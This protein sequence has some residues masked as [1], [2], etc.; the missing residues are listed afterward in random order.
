MLG[1]NSKG[2]EEKIFGR[3]AAFLVRCHVSPN[4]VTVAGTAVTTVIALTLFPLGRLWLGAVVLGLFATTD[5]LDGT[6]ARIKGTASDFGAFLDSTLDR[7][8]DA[9][10]LAGLTVYLARTGRV[11]GVAAGVAAIAASAIVPYAR[12]RAEALGYKAS[13]GIAE[14]SDRLIATLV[15][16]FLTGVGLPWWV[17]AGG[18]GLVAL[19]SL[20]TVGQRLAAVWRQARTGGAAE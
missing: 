19:G 4:V 14:R 1:A 6:M 17:L 9:A 16:A 15:A 10:M 11:I 3:P 5:A 7:V 13:V 8:S 2:L 20:I 18:L 12:A